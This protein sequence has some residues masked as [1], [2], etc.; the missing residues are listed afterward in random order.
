LKFF[1]DNCLS[2]YLAQAIRALSVPERHEVVHLRDRFQANA[3]D[4]D[5]ITALGQEGAWVIISGD[6]RISKNRHEREVWRQAQ[7]TTFFLAKGWMTIG[8]WEQ[9]ANLVRWWPKIVEQAHLVQAGAVFEVPIRFGS[10]K[11]KQP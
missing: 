5:W 3:P 2:P 8:F 7:L 6:P 1:F 11:F 9:A 10:G 4:V